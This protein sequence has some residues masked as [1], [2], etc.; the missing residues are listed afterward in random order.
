MPIYRLGE[1]LIFPHPL[2]AEDDG[3]LAIGGDLSVERLLLAYANGIFPWY[4]AGTPIVWHAPNPRFVLFPERFKVSK[5]LKQLIKKQKYTIKINTC[6]EKVVENCKTVYRPDQE[7]TWIDG[8][9]Q[10]AYANLHYLGYAHSVEVFNVKQKLVGGLY[11]VQLGQVFFGESMFHLESNTS[12]LAF[13]YLVNH[14][15]I[16]I[17]DCQMHTKHLESLGGEFTTMEHFLS[18]L[19]QYG[20]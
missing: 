16:R 7:D 20:K 11:G 14:F 15:N 5:S 12:K 4:N 13:H 8:A 19:K 3:V 17:I 9:M 2:L 18:L 6:F 10:K 1:K